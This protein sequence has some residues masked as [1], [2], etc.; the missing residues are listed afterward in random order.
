MVLTQEKD[1]GF[2][3]QVQYFTPSVGV[4]VFKKKKKR[5][6]VRKQFRK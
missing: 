1:L 6:Y 4:M 3:L 2:S 5:I